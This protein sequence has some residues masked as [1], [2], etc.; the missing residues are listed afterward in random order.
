MIIVGSNDNPHNATISQEDISME[1]NFEPGRRGPGGPG[2]QG[3]PGGEH[4]KYLAEA[5]G[6]TV[7]EL[8]AAME[9]AM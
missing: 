4:T 9:T 1:P 5:L 7:D 8:K 6:I 2:G 3:G